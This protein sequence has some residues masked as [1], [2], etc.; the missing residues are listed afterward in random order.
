MMEKC[1][2]TKTVY[3][4]AFETFFLIANFYF[5]MLYKTF[6]YKFELNPKL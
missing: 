4:F 6:A 3:L 5:F 2:I 1:V